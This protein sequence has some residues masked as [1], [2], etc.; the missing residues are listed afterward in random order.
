VHY[1]LVAGTS[2]IVVEADSTVG[3]IVWTVP[4]PLGWFDV[5]RV[6]DGLDIDAGI[7]GRLEIGLD[8]F[9]SGNAVYDA[10][11]RKRVDAR[12]Y[13]MAVVEL[14]KVFDRGD[15]HYGANATLEFHGVSR[16]VAGAIDVELA[17][18]G[19]IRV[20]GQER[21]DIRDFEIPTP[22]MLMLKIYPDVRVHLFL[23]GRPSA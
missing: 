4:E 7:S 8:R 19:A 17:D 22:S 5:K 10:E 16:P 14:V 12:Q 23:E 18:D 11:L 9:S 2:S 21:I 3:T 13:P 1:E 20:T 6:G 15:L